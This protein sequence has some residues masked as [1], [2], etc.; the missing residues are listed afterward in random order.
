MCIFL[1]GD[2][3]TPVLNASASSVA[4]HLRCYWSCGLGDTSLALLIF[5]Y[6]LFGD[7]VTPCPVLHKN[8]PSFVRMSAPPI[9]ALPD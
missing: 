9:T 1:F 8:A 6:F 4:K 2:G 7:G 3:V 5:I